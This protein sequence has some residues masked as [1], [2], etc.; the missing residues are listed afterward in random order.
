MPVEVR[1]ITEPEIPA[2]QHQVE[3]AF[4]ADPDPDELAAWRPL[5]EPDRTLGAFDGGDLVGTA[6]AFTFDMTVPGGPVPAAGVTGVGVRATHR[7]QGILTALMRRQLADVPEAFATLWASE[8]AIYGRYGYG[9]ASRRLHTTIQAHDPPLLGPPP[10]GRVRLVDLPE[11]AALAPP[12]YDAVRGDRPGMVSRSPRRWSTRLSDLPNHRAG[13]S[14]Q[15]NAV[16]ERDGEPRGYAWYRLKADWADTRPNG[17]VRVKEVVALDA[18]AHVGLW[19]YLLGIDLMRSV[20]WDVMPV[21]DPVPHRLADQRLARMVVGDGLHVRPLDVPRLLAGRAY[22]G[23]GRVVLDVVDDAG[24][25]AGRYALDASPDGATCERTT[26]SADLALSAVELGA[27]YLGDTPLRTLHE[28]GRV[29]E[30][31][32]GAVVRAS[33]L[34]AWDRPAWCA[35]IF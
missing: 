32:P 7:R 26:Q 2:L 13:A 20:T 19:R 28:A 24:Y 14:A 3:T 12:L 25:A 5:I 4:G 27:V 29:D 1:T 17:A 9:V 23:S 33:R 22:L 6:A 8:Q 15:R 34:L 10:A 30:H 31:T 21:D 11:M 18:D 35:E 16:Y